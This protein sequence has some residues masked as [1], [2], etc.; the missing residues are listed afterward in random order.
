MNRNEALTYETPDCQIVILQPGRI[1]DGSQ[2]AS[3]KDIDYE[4]L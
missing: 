2:Q 3:T 1:L 4:N